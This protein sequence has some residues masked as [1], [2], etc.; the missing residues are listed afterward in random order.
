[1]IWHSSD[2]CLFYICKHVHCEIYVCGCL[3]INA[4][5]TYEHIIYKT[6]NALMRH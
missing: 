1:M 5:Y 6:T 4:I 2:E 3:N